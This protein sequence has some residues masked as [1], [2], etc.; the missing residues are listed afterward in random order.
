MTMLFLKLFI[1]VLMVE[2]I[3]EIVVKSD[4]FYP[5]RKFLFGKKD[6]KIFQ[7]LHNLLD[8]GYCFSVWAG[9]FVCLLL[10]PMGNF[11]L[12]NQYIDWFFVGLFLHRLS[13]L[14]HF[15]L[16]VFRKLGYIGQGD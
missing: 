5:V 14:T 2:A 10:N 15:I 4:I 6:I 1:S 8:C 7:F 11:I 12:I 16:D 9:W 3:T 13:N